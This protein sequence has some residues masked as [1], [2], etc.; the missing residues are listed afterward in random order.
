MKKQT[1]AHR[2]K[3]FKANSHLSKQ[4]PQHNC[5]N[6]AQHQEYFF[7]SS[8]LWT[9]SLKAAKKPNRHLPAAWLKFMQ[10]SQKCFINLSKVDVCLQHLNI[11][12]IIRFPLIK[13]KQTQTCERSSKNLQIF[14]CKS[15]INVPEFRAKQFDVAFGKQ[16]WHAHK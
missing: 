15:K 16:R 10:R 4:L 11:T 8:L 6:P 1:L 5:A 3:Q 7:Y 14:K 12:R 2:Q 13:G 9:F